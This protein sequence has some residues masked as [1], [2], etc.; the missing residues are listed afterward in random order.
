MTSEE[1]TLEPTISVEVE[2]NGSGC[3]VR[4]TGDLEFATAPA[5]GDAVTELLRERVDPLVV[6]LGPLVFIDSTGLR[7]LVQSKQQ[8]EAQGQRFALRNL[9]ARTRRVFDLAGMLDEFSIE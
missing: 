1:S 5:L 4:V 3:V 7:L 2:R 8:T 6:D 9:N